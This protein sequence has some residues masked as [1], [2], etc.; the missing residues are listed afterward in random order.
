MLGQFSF[1]LQYRV[2]DPTPQSPPPT[3]P[4]HNPLT[5]TPTPTLTTNPLLNSNPIRGSQI[6]LIDIPSTLPP[7]PLT[8]QPSPLPPPTPPP[9]VGG[10]RG[11]V[12]EGAGNLAPGWRQGAGRTRPAVSIQAA[13]LQFET[14]VIALGGVWTGES[15]GSPPPP[16][17]RPWWGCL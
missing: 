9:P 15:N 8:H 11:W 3:Q 10:G 5:H 6:K 7:P 4:N 12:R 14:K 1:N 13:G 16:P 2:A 17:N